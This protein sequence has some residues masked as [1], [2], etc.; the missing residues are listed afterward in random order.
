MQVDEYTVKVNKNNF[1][2]SCYRHISFQHCAVYRE[3][4]LLTDMWVNFNFFRIG[5]MISRYGYC[6]IVLKQVV[7][8]HESASTKEAQDDIFKVVIELCGA[9]K[10]SPSSAAC[11]NLDTKLLLFLAIGLE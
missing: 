10:H 5:L 3:S 9:V 6:A 7:L 1:I 11:G 8:A 4:G 2:I